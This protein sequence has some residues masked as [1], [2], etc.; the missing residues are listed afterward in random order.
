MNGNATLDSGSIDAKWSLIR[1]S[2]DDSEIPKK[3]ARYETAQLLL[4]EHHFATPRD[5]EKMW[6]YDSEVGIYKPNCSQRLTVILES[7][8]GYRYTKRELDAITDKLK[9]R[10]YIDRDEFDSGGSVC[11][12]NGVLDL[13]N[14]ELEAHSPEHLFTTRIPV[15]YDPQA[16]CPRVNSFMG[17]IVGREADKKVLLEMVGN[18]LLPHYD[19][20]SFLILFGNGGNGK[21]TFLKVVEEFLGEDN[22]SSA[23]LQK[24]TG[25]RF[26]SAE[27]VGS[28]ANIA[29]DIGKRGLKNTGTLK[30]LTGGDSFRAERK[31]E[32]GFTFQNRAKLMFGANSPPDLGEST[33]AIKRR[34]L[35]IHL[36]NNFTSKDDDNPDEKP[37]QELLEGL[38]TPE[39]L[40]GLLNEAL[41]G[42]DRLHEH[43]DFSIPEGPD[44]RLTKYNIHSNPTRAFE[45]EFLTNESESTVR[46]DDVF[47]AFEKWCD[48][49]GCES[50]KKSEFYRK[51]A[52]TNLIVE[53]GRTRTDEGRVRILKGV[54][55]TEGGYRFLSLSQFEEGEEEQE[56]QHQQNSQGGWLEAVE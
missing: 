54:D 49:I 28:M 55:M 38:T 24:L 30:S 33:Y 12:G 42:I 37:R 48:S 25:G 31:Y 46:K 17:D 52:K 53:T 19:Y 10:T 41:D 3:K 5:T 6:M 2:Y 34:L 1:D 23:E 50:E 18:C 36:P 9:P 43:G 39:E 56:Q 20:E 11:V 22:C 14:R 15:D 16:E 44:E 7:E 29:P 40:S 45:R 21:T 13:Q 26:T 8:L 47:E 35:P 27:L 51:L 4:E 32:Q